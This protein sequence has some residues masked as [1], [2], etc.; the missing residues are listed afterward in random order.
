MSEKKITVGELA[1]I[2]GISARTV[3]LAH[4]KYLGHHGYLKG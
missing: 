1:N 2:A 3:R 4:Q